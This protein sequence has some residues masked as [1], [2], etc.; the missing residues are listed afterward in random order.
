MEEANKV[1]FEKLTFNFKG[2]GTTTQ[3][4]GYMSSLEEDDDDIGIDFLKLLAPIFQYFNIFNYKYTSSILIR[5]RYNYIGNED[6]ILKPQV[7][8]FEK[9]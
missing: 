5:Y 4:I 3:K 1:E 7:I 8:V 2:K 9:S 6:E